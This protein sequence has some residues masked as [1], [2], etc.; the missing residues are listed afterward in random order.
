M[1]PNEA[2]FILNLNQGWI[3]EMRKVARALGLPAIPWR[4]IFA[5]LY[6]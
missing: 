6:L 1:E 3:V 4:K 5:A 2:T